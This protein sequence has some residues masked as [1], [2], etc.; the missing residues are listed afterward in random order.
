MLAVDPDEEAQILPDSVDNFLSHCTQ[1]HTQY[2]CLR[3]TDTHT[4]ACV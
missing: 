4:L 1:T 2:G 3:H